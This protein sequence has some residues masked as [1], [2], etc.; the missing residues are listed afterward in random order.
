[1]IWFSTR[2]A[3]AL[4]LIPSFLDEDDPRSAKEQFDAN[5]IGGWLA[6]PGVEALAD[7]TLCY[8]GDPPLEVW[9]ITNLRDEVI[10]VFD[11][12]FVSITQPDGSFEVARL[13]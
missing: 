13:D 8:P 9:A 12:S 1:M 3:D 2:P 10:R 5:Y 4:G 11:C 7:G 6:L